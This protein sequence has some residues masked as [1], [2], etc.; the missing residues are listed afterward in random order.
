MKTK[1]IVEGVKYK[2]LSTELG[3]AVPIGVNKSNPKIPGADDL[4][5]FAKSQGKYYKWD[6]NNRKFVL[7]HQPSN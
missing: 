7:L 4:I 3:Y 2:V 6:S 1:K 5:A